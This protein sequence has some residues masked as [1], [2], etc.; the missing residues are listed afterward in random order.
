MTVVVQLTP[1][2]AD[3]Q[4]AVAAATALGVRLIP[5]H[6]GVRN[7]ELATWYVATSDSNDEEGAAVALRKLSGV[8]AAYVRP[9][10]EPA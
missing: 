5:M 10:A 2:P 1:V 8:T 6:P 9:G 4:A 7:A 3:A